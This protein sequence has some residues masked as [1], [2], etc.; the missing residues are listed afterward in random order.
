VAIYAG[1]DDEL[2]L[3]VVYQFGSHTALWVLLPEAVESD[4]HRLV[5]IYIERH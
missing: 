1:L 2:G 4:F 3:R 5:I